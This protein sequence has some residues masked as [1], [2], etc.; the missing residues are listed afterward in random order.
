VGVD[1]SVPEGPP[2]PRHRDLAKATAA[3]GNTVTSVAYRWVFGSASRF[4]RYYREVYSVP[5]SHTPRDS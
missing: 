2:R 4:A 3:D 5:P 1:G